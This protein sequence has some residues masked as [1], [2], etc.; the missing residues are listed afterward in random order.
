MP[1]Q[2]I[3]TA[4]VNAM[5]QRRK[6]RRQRIDDTI[7]PMQSQATMDSVQGTDVGGDSSDASQPVMNKDEGILLASTKPSGGASI[8][9][10]S[11]KSSS[12][13]SGCVTNPDGTQTCNY[14]GTKVSTAPVKYP[15]EL[16]VPPT[17]VEAETESAYQNRVWEFYQKRLQVA[18]ETGNQ[19]AVA[20]NLKGRSEAQINRIAA[21]TREYQMTRDERIFNTNKAAQDAAQEQLRLLTTAQIEKLKQEG[22]AAITTADAAML[23]AE[24]S[25]MKNA[26]EAESLRDKT[27]ADIKKTEAEVED[28]KVKTEAAR[29]TMA[30]NIGAVMQKHGET[31][32]E[33]KNLLQYADSYRSS[34]M[35]TLDAAPDQ[36]SESRNPATLKSISDEFYENGLRQGAG[37]LAMEDITKLQTYESMVSSG[38]LTPQEYEE[39]VKQ[40]IIDSA[41]NFYNSMPRSADGEGPTAKE[42]W[43]T[44]MGPK[45]R[46]ALADNQFKTISYQNELNGIDMSEEE[47]RAK[48]QYQSE[49]EF[50]TL[51]PSIIDHLDALETTQTEPD[52]TWAE[53]W[54][55]SDDPV[56]SN[57]DGLDAI[58]MGAAKQ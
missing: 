46:Q 31:L 32:L 25:N 10:A 47:V 7:D 41:T 13:V 30:S 18:I 51:A 40:S 20:A 50:Q 39:V 1:E 29:E 19:V 6:A 11:T 52:R 49:R 36:S 8:R 45:W 44:V 57:E 14:K 23:E 12:S 48:A 9:M 26:A 55:G 28:L 34:M 5:P 38:G 15:E 24:G 53:Y 21:L 43:A 17:M 27:A 42:L 56:D 4:S 3:I 37:I 33:T 16:S 58:P 2:N 54:F 35:K 22:A